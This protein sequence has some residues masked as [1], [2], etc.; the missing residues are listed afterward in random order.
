MQGM[1]HYFTRLSATAQINKALH[2]AACSRKIWTIIAR[3][4]EH[5]KPVEVQKACHKNRD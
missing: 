1:Q 5:P 4:R 2:E 3:A